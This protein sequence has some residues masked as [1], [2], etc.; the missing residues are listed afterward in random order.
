MDA[1]HEAVARAVFDGTL[2]EQDWP[3]G[4]DPRPLLLT[5]APHVQVR[6]APRYTEQEPPTDITHAL[7]VEEYSTAFSASCGVIVRRSG[8]SAT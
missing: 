6:R 2:L 3:A 1:A 5:L 8:A 4:Y 7:P